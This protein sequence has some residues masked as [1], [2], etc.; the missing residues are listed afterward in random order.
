M[1]KKLPKGLNS[2][3]GKYIDPEGFEPSGGEAQRLAIARA[4]YRGGNI[5]LLDEPTAALDPI[6]EYEIYSQFNDMLTDRC[7]ILITHR[8]SAVQLA[9]KVAVFHNGKVIEYGTHSELYSQGGVYTEMFDKQ[10]QFYRDAPEKAET[11]EV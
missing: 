1:F 9:D 6:Q 3:V 4:L 11:T 2:Q 7:A 5:Y 10:A 8:L